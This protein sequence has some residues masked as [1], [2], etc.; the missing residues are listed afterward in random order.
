[1]TDGY[2][3]GKECSQCGGR[4]CREK[5]CCLSP[6]D[7][8]RALGR[9]KADYESVLRLL[10]DSPDRLYAIDYMSVPKGF[11]QGEAPQKLPPEARQSL[12]GGVCFYLRMRHKCYTFVGVDAAGEC[13]ALG[14]SGCMLD[15]ERR[16]KGGRMLKSSADRN[17]VQRYTAG[18]MCGDWQPYQEILGRIYREFFPRMEQ[19]GTFDRCDEAYFAWMRE[20][21]EKIKNRGKS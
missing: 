8:L 4:C 5:G 2:R 6:E 14:E 13:A 11:P 21:A 9:E 17:C 19:D 18:E 1:M 7:M 15:W 16:P 12:S 10:K 20:R 3:P